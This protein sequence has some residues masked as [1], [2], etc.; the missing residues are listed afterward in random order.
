MSRIKYTSAFFILFKI[1]ICN[2]YNIRTF[3]STSLENNGKPLLVHLTGNHEAIHEEN[4]LRGIN[5][6][7]RF[8]KS[9]LKLLTNNFPERLLKKY[10]RIVAKELFKKKYIYTKA[11][12][13]KC[14]HLAKKDGY[15][16]KNKLTN[17]QE[18]LIERRP[19]LAEFLD[20]MEPVF[21]YVEGIKISK[22]ILDVKDY[23]YK[24]LTEKNLKNKTRSVLRTIIKA[25]TRQSLQYQL[26]LRRLMRMIPIE[27][28][29]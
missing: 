17:Y 26:H 5:Y 23:G 22:Y 18:E 8:I 9:T 3:D 1:T 16:I 20:A 15:K 12:A 10:M 21:T 28:N 29:N 6:F 13:H 2:S 7:E 25:V 11:L 19:R 27:H 14:W 4:I 24:K